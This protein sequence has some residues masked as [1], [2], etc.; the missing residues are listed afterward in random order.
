MLGSTP[1]V[2]Q[3]SA[4]VQS[5]ITR[6]FDQALCL[7]REMDVPSRAIVLLTV[8]VFC[9]IALQGSRPRSAY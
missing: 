6:Q 2:R 8:T 5:V 4:Q 1:S 7:L 3:W 9:Y